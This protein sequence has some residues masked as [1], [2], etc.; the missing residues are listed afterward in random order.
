MAPPMLGHPDDERSRAGS[1]GARRIVIGQ[2]DADLGRVASILADAKIGAQS[3]RP[4]AVFMKVVS[5]VPQKQQ[6]RLRHLDDARGV[7][8]PERLT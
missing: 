6:I 4:S 7:D 5:R 3:R 8:A 1:V 2:P